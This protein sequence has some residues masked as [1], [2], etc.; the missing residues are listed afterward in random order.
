MGLHFWLPKAHVEANTRG[1][2][3]L[4]G[5]LLKLGSY[6][7]FQILTLVSVASHLSLWL[8]L[9]VIASCLTFLQ[10]DTKKFIAFRSVTHM[11]FMMVG[12]MTSFKRS[13]RV[14]LILSLAHG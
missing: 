10:S 12:L 8:L 14:V 3:V 9:S 5:L 1:S 7:L 2:M 6:G 13:V 4:A 11:T